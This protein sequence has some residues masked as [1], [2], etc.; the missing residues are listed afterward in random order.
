MHINWLLL[1]VKTK[2]RIEILKNLQYFV[3]LNTLYFLEPRTKRL[4]DV[5]GFPPIPG[6]KAAGAEQQFIATLEAASKLTSTDAT[7]VGDEEEE[8]DEKEEEVSYLLAVV[9]HSFVLIK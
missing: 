3:C 6:Q 4:D 7:E 2:E 1:Q 5:S 8:D 9:Y